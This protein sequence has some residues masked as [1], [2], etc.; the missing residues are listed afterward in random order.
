MQLYLVSDIDE[1]S[2][3][4]GP[5]DN[6]PLLREDS[7]EPGELRDGLCQDVNY[8]LVPQEA[9]DFLVEHFTLNPGQEPI[10]RKVK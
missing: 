2:P 5:I 1:P 10:A 4:P 9:W 7:D 3:H 8:A 6:S